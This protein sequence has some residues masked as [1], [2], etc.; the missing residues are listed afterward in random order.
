MF[1][2]IHPA[3][4]RPGIQLLR[5]AC[6]HDFCVL[7]CLMEN[8]FS[9]F[10]V[11]FC[12]KKERF[13]S[14]CCNL[15][16]N[17]N[18]SKASF[19][20]VHAES[21]SLPRSN[22]SGTHALRMSPVGGMESFIVVLAETHQLT[23]SPCSNKFSQQACNCTM[24]NVTLACQAGT[25]TSAGKG[26]SGN[27]SCWADISALIHVLSKTAGACKQCNKKWNICL[28]VRHVKQLL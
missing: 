25:T 7:F 19:W 14:T 8:R 24:G 27:T 26:A 28:F 10:E 3:F 12:A 22:H 21:V 20:F 2:F 17:K 23:G 6:L 5:V 15:Y 4:L 1:S 9:S 18:L 13:T 16:E 11:C